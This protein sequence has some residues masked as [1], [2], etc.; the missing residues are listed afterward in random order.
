M[1]KYIIYII[2]N[3]IYQLSSCFF[4]LYANTYLNEALVRK[5][6]KWNGNQHRTDWTGL[7]GVAIIKTSALLVEAAILILLIYFLNRWYLSYT[8]G[9]NSSNKILIWTV[10]INIILATCFIAVLIWGSFKGYLW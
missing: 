6:L 10:R 7:A 9:K 1:I 5:S 2:Y 8:L 4:F 3:F